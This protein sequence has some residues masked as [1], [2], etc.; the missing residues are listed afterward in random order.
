MTFRLLVLGAL[1]LLA[2]SVLPPRLRR[3]ATGFRSGSASHFPI[4]PCP[5]LKEIGAAS[6]TFA[7]TS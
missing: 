5:T 6:P 2:I 3:S 4:Y 1:V 7:V